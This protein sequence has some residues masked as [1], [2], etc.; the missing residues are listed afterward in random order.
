MINILVPMAGKSYFFDD[1]QDGFPKPFIEICGKTMLEHFIL[2]YQN[3]DNK[4]FIFIIQDDE[5]RKFGLE[6]AINVLTNNKS[7]VLVLKNQT[8]GMACS[9]LMATEFI[10]NDTPL[11]IANMDQIFELDLNLDIERLSNFDAGVLSFENIHPR[12]SYIK[13]DEFDNI[14]QASEKKQISK[15]AIAGFYYFKKGSDFILAAKNM[16]KKILI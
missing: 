11:I 10:D 2:N 14:V 7:Q 9:A 13:C 4:R 15:N 6:D 1:K 5:N 12:F 3:I 16:I 8:A